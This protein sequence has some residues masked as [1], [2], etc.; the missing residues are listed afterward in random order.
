MRIRGLA[1]FD[2]PPA[3]FL[4]GQAL[5]ESNPLDAARAWFLEAANRGHALSQNHM[6]ILY[7]HGLGVPRD[8]DQAIQWFRLA[9]RQNLAVAQMNLGISYLLGRGTVQN[10]QRARY[11]LDLAA[12][13]NYQPARDILAA[14]PVLR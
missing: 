4:L 9:A 13:Q 14:L 7:S 8:Y 11:W 12:A 1:H 2:E 5:L 10:P 6:G 3:Q